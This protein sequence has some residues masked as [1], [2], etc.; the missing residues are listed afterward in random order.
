MSYDKSQFK[1]PERIRVVCRKSGKK[2]LMWR[3][4]RS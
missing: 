1:D 2:R 4:K 3:E